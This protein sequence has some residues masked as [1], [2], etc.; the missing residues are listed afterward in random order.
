MLNREDEIDRRILNMIS[1]QKAKIID[2]SI[3]Q[4]KKLV[5]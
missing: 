3:E 1:E 4:R 2:Y 5:E